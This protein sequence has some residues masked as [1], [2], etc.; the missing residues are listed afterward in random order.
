MSTVHLLGLPHTQTVKVEW[1]QCAFTGKIRR[2]ADMLTSK[3]HEVIL[4]G[5]ERND[6][7]VAEHVVCWDESDR[8]EWFG[9]ETWA[10]RVFDRWLETDPCW[11]ESNMKMIGQMRLRM[12]PGDLI[13][14]PIGTV[15]HAVSD[16]FPKN[17][18]FE[19]GIGYEGSWLPFRVFESYAWMHHTYG[20]QGI[21]DGRF[22]DAVIPNAF[23]PDDFQYRDDKD[24]YILFLGRHIPRKGLSIVEEVSKYFKVVTAGQGPE[25]EGV[26]YLGVVHG[27][28]KAELI[29]GARALLAPTIYIEPFGGVAVEAQLSGT[30]VITTDFGAFPETVEQGVTGFRCHTLAEFLQAAE[31]VDDLLPEVIQQKAVA[32]YSTEVVADQ[33][34]SYLERLGTLSGEG[35]YQLP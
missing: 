10:E 20:R 16:A 26:E 1:D 30:P 17:I 11:Y 18:A 2:L 24:D 29:A 5:A 19:S 32:K 23:D 27:K 25:I 22:Y 6:A 3:G 12:K 31:E 9:E 34:D 7:A 8:K 28:E 35:W 15:Q 4:Y 14:M 21:H 13:A 33:Y